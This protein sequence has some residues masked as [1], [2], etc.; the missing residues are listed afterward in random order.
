M[1]N[2]S[3]D[4]YAELKD[5]LKDSKAKVLLPSDG[6]KYEESLKRWSEHCEKRAVRFL[7]PLML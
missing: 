6:Q 2:A 4:V 3:A 5:Q 7:L 1:G